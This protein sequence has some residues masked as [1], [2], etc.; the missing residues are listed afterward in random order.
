M[1]RADGP[2]DFDPVAAADD[3]GAEEDLPEPAGRN[4]SSSRSQRRNLALAAL[5]LIALALGARVL[6][7][8][9]HAAPVGAST[10]PAT[11]SAAGGDLTAT[12]GAA[13]PNPSGS[14][15]L[16]V[17]PNGGLAHVPTIVVARASDVQCP[18]ADVGLTCVTSN[19][20]AAG[21]T[22]A[23]ADAFPGARVTSARA[24]A[25]GGA[26]EGGQQLHFA[27]VT[28]RAGSVEILVQV[29][30]SVVPTRPG[31]SSDDGRRTVVYRTYRSAGYL[32]QVEISAPSGRA[33]DLAGVERFARDPRLLLAP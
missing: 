32:V 13:A 10:G 18:T 22:R 11:P 8:H 24:V 16:V 19:R 14:G 25:T 12:W 21:F 2:I 28:A 1:A 31:V 27:R 29:Q 23:V 15:V 3:P 4:R 20:V 7:K 9:D 30:Q 26:G 17:L 5:I 33:P 6:T